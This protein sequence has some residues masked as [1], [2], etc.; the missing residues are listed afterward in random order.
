[1]APM[2]P[3]ETNQIRDALATVQDP[4]LGK[5]LVTLGM[6]KDVKQDGA[7]LH[8]TIELT[9]PACPMK[10]RIRNDIEQ[11][12]GRAAETHDAALERIEVE[13]TAQVRPANEELREGASPLPNVKH[14]IAIG[15]GGIE[16]GPSGRARRPKERST[17]MMAANRRTPPMRGLKTRGG[18]DQRP[19]TNAIGTATSPNGQ[20]VF[21][22]KWPARMNRQAPMRPTKMLR[23]SATAFI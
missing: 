17:S 13:F 3:L 12:I 20:K 18:S 6:V 11:A 2:R 19:P 9:T 8:V 1:M 5:D 10:D 14:V 21:H 22:S 15:A 7:D 16:H 23:V 4:D